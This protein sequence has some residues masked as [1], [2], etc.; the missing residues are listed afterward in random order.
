MKASEPVFNG[1]TDLGLR[2][3][4]VQSDPRRLA[5]YLGKMSAG[6]LVVVMA[7]VVALCVLVGL[8]GAGPAV[9][10]AFALVW[11]VAALALAFRTT[12]RAP[13][14]VVRITAE[15]GNG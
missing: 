5:A 2:D 10:A 4:G 6:A 12:R 9:I 14:V 15:G 13:L 1:I 11:T 3:I 7:S 8:T